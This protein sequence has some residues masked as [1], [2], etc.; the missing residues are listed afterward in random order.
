MQQ[1]LARIYYF[2]RKGYRQRIEM[3]S[4]TPK[5]GRIIARCLNCGVSFRISKDDYCM[6]IQNNEQPGL[7]HVRKC[8]D[9][10]RET[11]KTAHG[12]K[13][14]ILEINRLGKQ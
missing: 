1:C 2:I 3:V 9:E 13:Q 7:F 12:M 14:R 10:Y 6:R 8:M 4:S 11:H 5:P